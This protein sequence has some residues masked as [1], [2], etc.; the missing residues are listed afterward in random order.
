LSLSWPAL[1]P[2]DRTAQ[3]IYA[4]NHAKSAADF[5]SALRDFD[6]PQQNIV[7][8]DTA[9]HIGFMAPAR[10]PLR[11]AGD[12]RRPVPGWSGAYDWT[13][14]IPFEELPA[15]QD[16]ASGSFVAANNK[17]VPDD[18]PYL[19]TANWP[20][21]Y[22]AERIDELLASSG[23]GSLE[24]S[25]AMQQD[26]ISLGARLLLP[27]LLSAVA[28]QEEVAEFVDLLTVWNG[29][30]ERDAPE[31]LIYTTWI[32][33]LNEG[34]LSD[35][36]GADFQAYRRPDAARL[37]NL[38]EQHPSWCDNRD[39]PE[40]EDCQTVISISLTKAINF[41]GAEYGTSPQKWRWGAAHIAYFDHPLFE[42]VPFI[43]EW[44]SYGLETN[45][46]ED[47]LNRGVSRFAGPLDRLFEHIVG[48][49]YRAVY[50]LGDLDASRFMIATGQS[51]NHIDTIR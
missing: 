33:A 16:P 23:R 34:L 46:G 42:Q 18:Y 6:A 11:K 29:A 43:G 19:I 37:A 20:R 5:K 2:D 13:G 4:M 28:S 30:M 40:T 21:P 41:L 17:I 49:G 10:V 48:A 25:L 9:G 44:I 7:Y 31:P 27:I 14:F 50:D 47:S 3:A 8:A 39:T 24:D 45:G 12:G 22:R 36:L 1:R 32:T 38:L 26:T 15:A 51:G 35:E